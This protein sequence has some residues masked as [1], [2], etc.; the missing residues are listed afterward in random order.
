MDAN[1]TGSC[2]QE[3]FGLPKLPVLAVTSDSDAAVHAGSA[4]VGG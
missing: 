3:N 4:T 1:A 2:V